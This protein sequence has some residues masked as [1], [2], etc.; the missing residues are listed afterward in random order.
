MFRFFLCCFAIVYVLISPAL[1]QPV[2]GVVDDQKILLQS[3]AAQ[4]IQDQVKKMRALYH[5]EF[6]KKAQDFLA[7]EKALIAARDSLSKEEFAKKVQAFEKRN[8]AVQRLAQRKKRELDKISMDA[9][10]ELRRMLLEIVEDVLVERGLQL[11]LSYKNVLAGTKSIDITDDVMKRLN[12]KVKHI[13][14]D[15]KLNEDKKAQSDG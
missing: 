11:V 4:S 14:M 13:D 1:A 3:D 2:I 12:E 8:I 10:N 6:S 7:E 9:V 15:I 5:A